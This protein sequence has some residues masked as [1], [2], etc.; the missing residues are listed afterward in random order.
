M[1]E[2]KLSLQILRRCWRP[3]FEFELLF[4][5][6]ALTFFTP[7][8]SLG[9][10]GIMAASHYSYL[11]VDNVGQFFRSPLTWFLLALLLLLV[12]FYV[13]VDISAILYAVDQGHRGRETELSAMVAAAARSAVRVFRPRNWVL[14]LTALIL[15]PLL[16]I[17]I[18]SGFVSTVAIPEAIVDQ[19]SKHTPL[20]IAAGIALVLLTVLLLRWMY[21]FHYYALEGCPFREAR[22]RS[23]KLGR[24]RHIRDLLTI[25]LLQ[26]GFAALFLILALV[27]VA[28]I[29]L[30][31]KAFTT[32]VVLNSILMSAVFVTL[33][34]LLLVFTVL[35]VPLVFCCVSALYYVRKEEKQVP[36]RA[37]EPD[38]P[39]VR[40]SKRRV[41]IIEAAVLLVSLMCGTFYI[42]RIATGEA[43]FNIEY[44][45][46][47]EVTAHRGASGICPENTMPAF[48]AAV[49]LGADWIELDVQQTRDGQI[50]VMHDTNL[51]RTTGLDRNI[52][53]IDY[54]ELSTLDAGSWFSPEFAGTRI[55]LLSE[56][57]E[58]ARENH[59]RLNIELKPTGHEENFAQVVVDLVREYEF[60]EDC[61]VTSQSYATLQ[62]V[63]ECDPEVKTVY[64]MGVAYGNL[65]KLDAADAFS[66]RA[67][68]ITSSMVQ[69]LHNGHKELY[70]WTVNTRTTVE[71]MIRLGVDNVI[72]DYVPM[73]K[74]C[75]YS[76]KTTNLIREY[77]TFLEN[78]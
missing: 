56:V 72:T 57:L 65:L 50:V 67:V 22:R 8:V 6:L 26:L 36:L 38:A 71:K 52:W 12:A 17:G 76:S 39:R 37:M 51:R 66:V 69:R 78:F 9:F 75:V 60:V 18:V 74:D 31:A 55:P 34:V 41:R 59:V 1:K 32:A 19:L 11:T 35:S 61:V 47:M 23:V 15:L 73:A 68:N 29:V 28:C 4:K 10:R 58:F 7:L 5:L 21:I 63:R 20:L 25:L 54:S 64:V 27:L 13:V 48:E 46:T 33:S 77:V 14:A 30:I 53:E 70:A 3:L 42:Y 24:K 2:W 16:N 45:H 40:P 62:E 49:E 43:N 44:I